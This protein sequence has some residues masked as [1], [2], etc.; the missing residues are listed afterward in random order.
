MDS[1]KMTFPLGAR[2]I[3]RGELLVLGSVGFC[4]LCCQ[5][6]RFNG[7]RWGPWNIWNALSKWIEGTYPYC[8]NRWFIYVS[9]ISTSNWGD[10]W[11]VDCILARKGILFWGQQSLGIQSPK[12]R[13]A[14]Q[15]KYYAFG[16]AWTPTIIFLQDDDPDPLGKQIWAFFRKIPKLELR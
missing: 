6:R 13:M 16:C 11:F 4:Y 12:L 8:L 10:H 5:K 14:M 1:W 9:Y 2:P 3:F 7:R 15:P